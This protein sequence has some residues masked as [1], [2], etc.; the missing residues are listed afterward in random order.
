[1]FTLN[2]IENKKFDLFAFSLSICLW[3]KTCFF[4]C[5]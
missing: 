1:M 4:W 5:H 2:Y 3:F